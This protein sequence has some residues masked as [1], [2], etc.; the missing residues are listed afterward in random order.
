MALTR[1]WPTT[2]AFVVLLITGCGGGGS[3]NHLPTTPVTVTVTYN[4]PPVEGA[5]V[6]FVDETGDHPAYGRTDAQGVAKLT[7]YEE[8]DGAVVGPYKVSI[9]K[10]EVTGQ[11]TADQDSAAYVPPDAS[12]PAPTIK[13]HIPKK[14]ESHASSRLT[15]EVTEA[16]PNDIKFDLKD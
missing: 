2:G 11:S 1:R 10:S 16:G 12:T 3:G 8:G 15:A 5:T 4:G 7:S 14:Y 9:A 6:T 13:Y